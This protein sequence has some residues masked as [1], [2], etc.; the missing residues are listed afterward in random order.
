V[1]SPTE[2]T[3]L[4]GLSLPAFL[5]AGVTDVHGAWLVGSDGF[6]LYA[7]GKFQRAAPMPPGPVGDIAIAGACV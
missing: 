5:R 7:D 1:S 2:A 6:Y 3:K 4:T